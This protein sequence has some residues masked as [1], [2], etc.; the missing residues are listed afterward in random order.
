MSRTRWL[1]V[2][3]VV[4]VLAAAAAGTIHARKM[5][6]ARRQ[7][8]EAQQAWEQ[9]LSYVRPALRA[10]HRVDSI[11]RGG[12]TLPEYTR[13][14]DDAQ[15]AL[16]RLERKYP[17]EESEPGHILTLVNIWL[18]L[19]EHEV[20][21]SIWKDEI[22]D[23][24]SDPQ[25]SEVLSKLR[26]DTWQSAHQHIVDSDVFLALESMPEADKQKFDAAGG[27]KSRPRSVQQYDG[28]ASTNHEASIA[29]GAVRSGIVDYHSLPA[30]C[31]GT[32]LQFTGRGYQKRLRVCMV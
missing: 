13:A 27:L 28:S 11:V 23:S 26:N 19:S 9:Y 29:V 12:V 31:M 17:S 20:A 3:A 32:P 15:I 8:W 22:K 14:L 16:D 4:V 25:G 1:V 30:G 21:A 24:Y 10:L 7:R 2:L 18:A 6:H 5:L